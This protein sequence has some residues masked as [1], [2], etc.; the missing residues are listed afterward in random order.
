MTKVG[1]VVMLALTLL[2]AAVAAGCGG[3]PPAGAEKTLRMVG[4]ENEGFLEMR[5]RGAT[6]FSADLAA[7]IADR[8]D[9][10]L[11]VSTAPFAEPFTQ[12]EEGDCDIAM[13]AI[14]ITPER[15]RGIGE[16]LRFMAQEPMLEA[17][18]AGALDAV[19]CDTPF[20]RYNA[21][22]TGATRVADILTEG[23]MY[24]IAVR[25]GDAKLVAEIDAALL[26]IRRDGTYDRLYREYFGE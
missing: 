11:V 7:A 4:N 5:G 24:G 13:S 3:A 18:A 1:V 12:L 2:M 19:I 25:K 15:I 9:R 6:G 10:T 21:K 8:M 26:A 22:T 17:L 16:I 23:E 20:A 14:S